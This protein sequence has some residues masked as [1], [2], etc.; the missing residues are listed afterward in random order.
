MQADP[1]IADAL[2]RHR[3]TAAE[4][5]ALAAELRRAL[6]ELVA[7]P[8]PHALGA[9]YLGGGYGRGEGGVHQDADGGLR[10]YNDLDFFAWPRPDAPRE[11]WREADA[12][13]QERLAALGEKFGVEADCPPLA[14]FAAAL[15]NT[16]R[17]MYQELKAGHLTLYR[18][19]GYDPLAD[20]PLLPPGALPLSEGA[21]LLLNRGFG[22]LLARDSE[23][24][25]G[26]RLRNLH[27]AALG[28]GDALLIRHH[29]YRWPGRERALAFRRLCGAQGWPAQWADAYDNALAFKY[30]PRER[31]P[32]QGWGQARAD[33]IARWRAQCAA[34]GD[35]PGRSLKS[36]ARWLLRAHSLPA[37]RDWGR[38]PV[39]LLLPDLALALDDRLPEPALARLHRLWQRFN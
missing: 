19:D 9:L 32:D 5:P 29:L 22:L 36:F 37:L 35:L 4:A 7:A 15:R 20:L 3:F 1:D 31:E 39:A 17:L 6:A 8:P 25:L 30:E 13:L 27:K 24:P 38:D 14:P 33:A 21:R 28:G 23:L 34:F 18:A 26:F 2:A 16:S 10:P 11:T 12:W